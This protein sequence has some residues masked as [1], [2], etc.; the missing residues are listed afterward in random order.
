MLISL[1][2]SV[3]SVITAYLNIVQ[4][5]SVLWEEAEHSHT[6]L[7]GTDIKGLVKNHND[8]VIRE[9]SDTLFRDLLKLRV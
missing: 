1:N 8:I 2:I 3:H 7:S 9:T 6:N 5:H 4:L